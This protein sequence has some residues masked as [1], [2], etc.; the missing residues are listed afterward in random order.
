MRT[1][2]LWY[3]VIAI[4]GLN[5][6]LLW[7]I[8][9]PCNDILK[10]KVIVFL[11]YFRNHSFVSSSAFAEIYNSVFHATHPAVTKC[12]EWFEISQDSVNSDRPGLVLSRK[13]VMEAFLNGELELEL[14]TRGATD[15]LPITQSGSREQVMRVIN[16]LRSEEIYP[17]P[18]S[19]CSEVCRQRG[20]S[21]NYYL[22]M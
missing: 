8:W 2:L 3:I 10:P 16:S 4:S 20:K 19:H 13:Q 5:P 17:H 9:Q 11:I 21:K 12:R 14:Q 18:P 6:M 15:S 1:K 22:Y 7:S